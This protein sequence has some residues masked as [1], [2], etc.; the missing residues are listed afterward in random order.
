MYSLSDVSV[1]ERL[2][3]AGLE[4]LSERGYKGATTR[5]IADRAGVAEVTLFRRFGS[6]ANLIAEAVRRLGDAFERVVTSPSGDLRADLLKLAAGYQQQFAVGG[7]AV[8][9]LAVE[10]AQIDELQKAM[11]EALEPRIRA[12]HDFFVHYQHQ[13]KL[14][15][16]ETDMMVN[17]FFGPFVGSAFFRQVAGR[18]PRFDLEEHVD[19]FIR[20]WS[21]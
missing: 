10:A 20:G 21:A 13:G 4:L 16:V 12:I 3:R 18:G 5:A 15:T 9:A 14:R 2:I 19:G 17:A 11:R 7:A 1:D 8:F 6:K